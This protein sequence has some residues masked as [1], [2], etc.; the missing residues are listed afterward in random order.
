VFITDMPSLNASLCAA[1]AQATTA[2][3]S[4]VGRQRE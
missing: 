2:I 1:R 4:E 3:S